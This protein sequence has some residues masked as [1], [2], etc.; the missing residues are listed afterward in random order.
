MLIDESSGKLFCFIRRCTVADGD[1]GD[2]VILDSRQN[3]IGSFLFLPF[4]H[5]D[6]Q[7][8]C[9]QYSTCWADN[10]HLA[11]CAVAWV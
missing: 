4:A 2:A 11:A 1:Q 10:S 5:G 3:R 6:I 7:C 9:F 8:A